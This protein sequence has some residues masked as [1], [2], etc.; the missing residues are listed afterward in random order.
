MLIY[1]G[2]KERKKATMIKGFVD[3]D[4]VG[5][6]DSRKSL[7]GYIFAAFGTIINWKACL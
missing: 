4:Y 3:S 2:A 5:C 1:G 6:L 7:T